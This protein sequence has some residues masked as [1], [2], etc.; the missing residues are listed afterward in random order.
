MKYKDWL[1]E[2]LDLYVKAFVKIRTYEKYEIIIR[3]HIVHELGE[4]ELD[5]LTVD[6]LQR[7]TVRLLEKLSSNYVN[8]VITVLR[9]SLKMAVK[10][11]VSNTQFAENIIRPKIQEK[12]IECFSVIEQRKIEI[13]VNNH[14]KNKM[15]GIIICLY[16]GLRIG[17]LLALQWSDVNFKKCLLSVTKSCHYGK[18]SDGKY[19]RIEETP[20]TIYSVRDIPISKQLMVYLKKLKTDNHS[21]YVISENQKPVSVRSYQNSFDLLLKRLNIPHKGFHALRHTFATRA[22]ENGVDVKTLSE[23]LGHK[24]AEVTLNRYTHSLMDHKFDVMNRLGCLMQ[25]DFNL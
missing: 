6:I 3:K 11:G 9:R 16:T 14:K 22:L 19:G 15:Y 1:S 5:K 10:L 7:F 23:I 8:S 20:K 4:Y 2:W 12:K 13:A 17:E 24:N 25:D 21:D 18:M